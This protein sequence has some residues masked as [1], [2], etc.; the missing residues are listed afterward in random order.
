MMQMVVI[1]VKDSF[2]RIYVPTEEVQKVGQALGN[3]I[4]WPAI[5]LGSVVFH[6]C[7]NYVCICCNWMD[8][9]LY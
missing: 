6:T 5:S 4:I 9:L 2:V 8:I 1:N 7:F 3:F